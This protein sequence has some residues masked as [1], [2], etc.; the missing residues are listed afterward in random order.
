MPARFAL[1]PQ[2]FA[3]P[4]PEMHQT[5]LEG[6]R[7]RLAV[8][9]A[10]HQDSAWRGRFAH[11][12]GNQS[13]G[14]V[15]KIQIH[16]VNPSTN[17]RSNLLQAGDGRNV[18]AFGVRRS[19]FGVRRVGGAVRTSVTLL[20]QD[21]GNTRNCLVHDL[22]LS[23]ANWYRA[24]K[25]RPD[26]SIIAP[27]RWVARMPGTGTLRRSSTPARKKAIV[28]K[29]RVAATRLQGAA[30]ISFSPRWLS[31]FMTPVER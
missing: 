31:W 10:H 18:W 6:F 28:G 19:A 27:G 9:P 11:D 22:I 23:S 15:L 5:G 2:L 4:A 30:R 20:G 16:R 26:L 3:R 8:H 21:I 17:S 29:S 1:K 24:T 14:G 7:K 13:I 25:W 12:C